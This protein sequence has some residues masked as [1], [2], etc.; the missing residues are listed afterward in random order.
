MPLPANKQSHSN[1]ELAKK[2]KTSQKTTKTF[3]KRKKSPQILNNNTN[4]RS[5]ADGVRKSP[6]WNIQTTKKKRY[7]E[8]IVMKILV[9]LTFHWSPQHFYYHDNHTWYATETTT[10]S[11]QTNQNATS[12]YDRHFSNQCDR[13]KMSK[14][15]HGNQPDN[16]CNLS[17]RCEMF[18]AGATREP[19]SF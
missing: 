3:V 12:N 16:H 8:Q 10:W 6:E 1:K 2:K 13:Y 19:K 4:N 5:W 11:L 7:K 18:V 9:C 17:E 15:V 14:V